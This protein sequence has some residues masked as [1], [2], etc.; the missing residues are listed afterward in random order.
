ML[1][2]VSMAQSMRFKVLNAVVMGFVTQMRHAVLV[3]KRIVAQKALSVAT[4]MLMS[5]ELSAVIPMLGIIRALE[6]MNM[7]VIWTLVVISANTEESMP[8]WAESARQY[9]KNF[10]IIFLSLRNM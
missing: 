4:A 9:L 7:D 8:P 1:L 6:H 5:M 10:W 3:G 2:A